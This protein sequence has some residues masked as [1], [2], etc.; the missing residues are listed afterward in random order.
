MSWLETKYSC[1]ST[2]T[3]C[4]GEKYSWRHKLVTS[5][6]WAPLGVYLCSSSHVVRHT[7]LSILDWRKSEM[8][9]ITSLGNWA[10]SPL[11]FRCR[12]A[13]FGRLLHGTW[14]W[15]PLER[16]GKYMECAHTYCD[17]TSTA[18]VMGYEKVC[19]MMCTRCETTRG[20]GQRLTHNQDTD[21]KTGTVRLEKQTT[22]APHVDYKKNCYI[23]TKR[24][25]GWRKLVNQSWTYTNMRINVLI[26]RAQCAATVIW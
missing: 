26:A 17:T 10:K 14:L 21:R 4:L 7:W 5:L 25:S 23:F 16:R 15:Q 24:R 20:H 1:Y 8:Y 12:R 19:A 11:S 9:G 3:S 6:V 22:L 13:R 2:E 18:I